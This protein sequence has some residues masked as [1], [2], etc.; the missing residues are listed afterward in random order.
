MRVWI[1]LTWGSTTTH[2]AAI[3]TFSIPAGLTNA[4][5]EGTWLGGARLIDTGTANYSRSVFKSGGNIVMM[6]EAG[7]FVTNLV[8]WTMGNTDQELIQFQFPI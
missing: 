4:A 8:P 6:S 5:T 7:A 1:T 3:Q 2:G